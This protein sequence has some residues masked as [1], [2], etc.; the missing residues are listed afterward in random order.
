MYVAI[1]SWNIGGI[2]LFNVHLFLDNYQFN[3]NIMKQSG[4]KLQM[5]K[6]RKRK[7]IGTNSMKSTVLI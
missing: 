7:K 5:E 4:I 6:N 3:P 2:V 1:I